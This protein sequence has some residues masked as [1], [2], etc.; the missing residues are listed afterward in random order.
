MI[1]SVF[2]GGPSP[3]EAAI[4]LALAPIG[5]WAVQGAA[6]L[7][8]AATPP[9]PPRL[10]PTALAAVGAAHLCALVVAPFWLA[11]ASLAL[12]WAL[13]AL[14]WID[15]R[16]LLLPD[17]LT[18]PLIPAGV[19]VGWASPGA[20]PLDHVIGAAAGFA[21]F[22]A[23][24]LGYRRLR[25]REGLGLGDAKLLAAGGAWLGWAG[26]PSMVLIAAV[27]ALAGSLV[28][29]AAGRAAADQETPFG[30]YLALGLW[31][32]WILGPLAPAG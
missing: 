24:G 19:A 10:D 9:R 13:L 1:E 4:L 29:A 8:G 15:L 23:L 32:V 16:T 12:G 31:M 11:L 18:L 2:E 25:G 3:A 26:L 21:F 17:Y 28:A 30:P 22:A 7:E 5:A 20:A 27:T 6:A 14:S